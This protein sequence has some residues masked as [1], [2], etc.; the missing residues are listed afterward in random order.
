MSGH[1][2]VQRWFSVGVEPVLT[3]AVAV[4]CLAAT[5]MLQAHAASGLRV[6]SALL[7][8]V[9][10]VPLLGWRQSPLGVF[11]VTTLASAALGAIGAAESLP[12][13]ATVALYLLASTR[14]E[15]R[16]WTHVT[17]TVVCGLFAIH[18]AAHAVGHGFST[19]SLVVGALVW[20]VA[21]F[22][23]ERTRLRREQIAEL[24]SRAR[25]TAL[26]AE[27][28]RRLA[29]AEERAR[30][31]RDLHDSAGHAMNV[32]GVQA[33]AA[34]LLYDRDPERSRAALHIIEQLARQTA[35]DIDTIVGSLRASLAD[36]REARTAETP[37]GLASV[38]T[39]LGQ[40]RAAG[41]AVRLRTHGRPRALPA[42]VDQA[43]FRILQETLTNAARHGAGDT[44]VDLTFTDTA[45]EIAVT[46][47]AKEVDG[48]T[49]G[50]HGLV[51][52]RERVTLLGGT[53]A[54]GRD[55]VGFRVD[56]RLPCPAG[57]R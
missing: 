52:M 40:R 15:R 36:D 38:E 22:A 18:V 48:H 30:I 25:H 54:A 34:R 8:G 11:A 3:V 2:V 39:L 33:G 46:N 17:T 43:A 57:V 37:R 32:I 53:F 5:L 56:A 45:L 10:C 55:G 12:L 20:G 27:R 4:G 31:A 49:D 14:D 21:W 29:A 7:S 50:G 26:D 1:R 42:A 44:V 13:G 41:L 28:E 16:P 24:Q 35:A 19:E 6:S 23:G 9:A 47:R 51:G